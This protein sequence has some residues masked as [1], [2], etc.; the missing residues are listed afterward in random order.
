MTPSECKL[1]N[2]NLIKVHCSNLPPVQLA[3][4]SPTGRCDHSALFLQSHSPT[5]ASE[6]NENS[7]TLNLKVMK[8][9]YINRETKCFI[10]I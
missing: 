9:F 4:L 2:K 1:I 7:Y 3:P 6:V 10:S 8:Y 5:M